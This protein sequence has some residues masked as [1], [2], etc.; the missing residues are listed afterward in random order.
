MRASFDQLAKLIGDETFLRVAATIS[1]D[2]ER[3]ADGVHLILEDDKIFV[4]GANDGQHAIPGTLQSGC[5]G[6]GHCGSDTAAP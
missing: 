3:V 5:R 4:A 6:V 1:S 2:H